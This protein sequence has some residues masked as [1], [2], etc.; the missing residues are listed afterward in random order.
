MKRIRLLLALIVAS[1]CSVQGTWA[2]TA[3][4]LPEAQTLESGKTYYLYNVGSDKFASRNGQ[5]DSPIARTDDGKAIK[6]SLV[7]GTQYSLQYSDDNFYWYS[8][9]EWIYV[10]TSN[11]NNRRFTMQSVDGGYIIQRE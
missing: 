7:N 10:T 6:I 9:S 3:P 11:G 1:I 8:S 4:T 2:R 5:W